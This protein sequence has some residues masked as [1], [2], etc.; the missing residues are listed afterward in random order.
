M[1]KYLYYHIYLTDDTGAWSGM[2]IDQVYLTI[3][4]GLYVELEKMYVNCIGSPEQIN[5]WYYNDSY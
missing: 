5:L 3:N 4:S 1:K 2:F